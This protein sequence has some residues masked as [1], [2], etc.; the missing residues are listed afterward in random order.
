VCWPEVAEDLVEGRR[1]ALRPGQVRGSAQARR[2]PPEREEGELY[3]KDVFVGADPAFAM[4]YRFVGEYATHAMFAHNMFPKDLKGVKDV[5]GAA[6]DDAQ[7][8][9]VRVRPGARR[10]R[11]PS[12]AIIIDVKNKIC[13]VAGRGLLRRGQ[14]D[15]LHGRQLPAA[16]AGPPV[17][18]LLGQRRP[19]G[20]G[21]I[22]FGLSGT[23][24][25]TLS[26]D[27]DRR[28]IG[29]DETIWSDNGLCNL[30]DGC[31]AKLI[32]LNKRPSR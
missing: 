7:R 11:A 24:K 6:L 9:V 8:A 25:T 29:D 18:A 19:A 5:E 3:V 17:D 30:E 1:A 23:G 2:R 22:L 15:D 4:P 21:A 13:L 27:P 14:E 32:D 31:Y 26:A 16:D 20:D 28:L 12:A 10:L